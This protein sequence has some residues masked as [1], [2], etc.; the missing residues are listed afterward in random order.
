MLYECSV[1][2][3]VN[4]IEG[5]RA[6][7]ALLQQAFAHGVISIAPIVYSFMLAALSPWG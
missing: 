3:N 6:Y 7:P 4:V 1:S 5:L 2:C